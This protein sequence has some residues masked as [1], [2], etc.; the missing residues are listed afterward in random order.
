[1]DET[2]TGMGSTGKNW[3]HQHWYLRSD[4]APDYVTFGG[5]SGLAGFYSTLEHR[6]NDEATAYDNSL[7][8][9]SVLSYGEVWRII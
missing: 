6:L 1:M 7:D 3:G 9:A 2:K 8:M 4:Q 5:K